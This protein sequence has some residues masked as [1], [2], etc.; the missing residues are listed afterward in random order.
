MTP[1][2]SSHRTPSGKNAG[3]IELADAMLDVLLMEVLAGQSP[4]DQRERIIDRLQ[5]PIVPSVVTTTQKPNTRSSSRNRRSSGDRGVSSRKLTWVTAAMLLVCAGVTVAVRYQGDAMVAK[6]EHAQQGD[7]AEAVSAGRTNRPASNPTTP[8][9]STFPENVPPPPIAL[10]DASSNADDANPDATEVFRDANSQPLIASVPSPKPASKPLTLV[11]TSMSNHVNQYWERIG[12]QPTKQLPADHVAKRLSDRLGVKVEPQAVGNTEAMLS[13]LSRPKNTESLAR[14]VLA[15][16]SSRRD[17]SLTRPVDQQMVA[18]VEKTLH[19]GRGF[20]R[21]IVSWFVEPA[22]SEVTT[23]DEHA[24]EADTGG[25]PSIGELLQPIGQHEAIVS[26]AA[27]TL[28]ADMRCVR[29]HDLPTSGRD[30]IGSQHEYWQFAANI[31]PGLGWKMNG[32]TGW[33]YDTIDGRRRLAEANLSPDW[34]RSLVGSRPLAEGLVGAMWEMVHGRPLTSAPYDLSGSADDSDLQRLRNELTNDLIAN[35]FNLLRTISLIMT[36]S[37]VG[38]STPDAMTSSGLLT[39]SSEQWIQAVTAV[40]AFAAAP[41]ESMPLSRHDRV[42]LVLAELPSAGSVASGSSLLAQ[43]LGAGDIGFE[44]LSGPKK[45]LPAE[46][47]KP[48]PAMVAG[49]PARATI[50]M[51][52]W[53]DKLPDF[54]SRLEHIANLAGLSKVPTRVKTL[55][56]QMRAA[57]L[58]E[59]LILQ[60]IWWI[61]RPQN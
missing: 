48:S 1:P 7:S 52:A 23:G 5:Q 36:D 61:I 53:M 35:D 2:E 38:R 10:A 46:I 60:R 57:D 18:Q 15:A 20:D 31:S 47:P 13:L 28:G 51:P 49:L 26:T 56:E 17:A 6:D 29:C 55:A 58:N 11:S 40:E 25:V 41:P 59:T 32:K 33:F 16:I 54:D 14:P 12:V 30:A 45:F 34:P 24:D 42:N 19:Q 43:P 21:L 27:L 50:V 37:I 22:K 9:P 44:E 3:D 39:A 4:P 8:V